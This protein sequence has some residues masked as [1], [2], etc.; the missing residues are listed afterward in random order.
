MKIEKPC[1]PGH[2]LKMLNDYMR[3]DILR[4][5]HQHIQ[6]ITA[7]VDPGYQ[8]LLTMSMRDYQAGYPDRA[9]AC[10][11]DFLGKL[12]EEPD[13]AQNLSLESQKQVEFYLADLR[14]L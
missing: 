5:V 1:S 10:L 12:K 11:I 4:S 7:R 9:G 2:C 14:E 3:T 13:Y 6:A 8:S